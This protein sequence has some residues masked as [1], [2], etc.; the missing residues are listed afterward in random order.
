[1]RKR[2]SSETS[3]RQESISTGNPHQSSS[4]IPT[5]TFVDDDWS[6]PPD[7]THELVD[8]SYRMVDYTWFRV[9]NRLPRLAVPKYVGRGFAYTGEYN[10]RRV[11]QSP[12]QDHVVIK[13]SLSPGGVT[14]PKFGDPV[15]PVEVGQAILRFV[16]EP[17]FWESYDVSQKKP[18]EFL[19]LIVYGEVAG[20]IARSLIEGYGRIY[21]LG[22]AHPLIGQ[23]RQLA[24]EPNHVTE[25][26]AS[27]A[28][29]LCM[30]LF[31]ALHAK[32]EVTALGHSLPLNTLAETV[33]ATMRKNM[34]YEWTVDE[35]AAKHDVSREHLTRVF[36]RRYG[37]PPHRY[38]VELRVQE[39]CQRLRAGTE[40]IK[41]I[42]LSLGFGSHANFIRTFRRYNGVSPT[43]Y[44]QRRLEK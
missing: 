42:F 19:G 18:W 15:T 36:T 7:R 20:Q 31:E 38:L 9:R 11:W 1:M 33:E 35:L 5:K 14:A 13:V 25:I 26:A 10:N 30:E 3:S 22:V 4:A 37:T 32:A 44:R 34:R 41:S 17:E 29:R 2:S 27:T 43:V 39:A 12:M 8:N 28:H 16:E 40:S 23:L 6:L 24:S 21:D